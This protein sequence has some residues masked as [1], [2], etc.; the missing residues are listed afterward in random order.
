MICVY[1]DIYVINSQILCN[2]YYIIHKIH[3]NRKPWVQTA[4]IF[5]K[6]SIIAVNQCCPGRLGHQ[7]TTCLQ[8]C[9]D[10]CVWSRFDAGEPKKGS[11][12]EYPNKLALHTAQESTC[13]H[14]REAVELNFVKGREHTLFE[15][16]KQHVS[17]I[18]RKEGKYGPVSKAKQVEISFAPDGL[19]RRMTTDL[20]GHPSIIHRQVQEFISDISTFSPPPDSNRLLTLQKTNP[21]PQSKKRNRLSFLPLKNVSFLE[22]TRGV[23]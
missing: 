5:S 4:C 13:F 1:I 11:A 7:S 10:L 8:G 2:K 6:V 16:K 9:N 21:Y 12:S 19:V 15:I 20:D 3:N 17:A 14:L 23:F 18:S 22:D